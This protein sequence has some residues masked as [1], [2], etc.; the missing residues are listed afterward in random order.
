MVLHPDKTKFMLFTRSS[1]DDDPVLYC[2]NNNSNQNLSIHI[3]KLGRV[4][5][6]DDLPAIKFLGVYFDLLINCKHHI[7][8]LKNKLSG[9][10][11]ALR[12][13]KNI[14]NQKAYS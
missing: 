1:C 9:A 5:S 2:N 12:T 13:V 8:V 14:L 11:Y 3:S 4:T 6:A 7:S 10:L